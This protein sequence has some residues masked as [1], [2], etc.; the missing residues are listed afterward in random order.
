MANDQLTYLIQE[1]L[2]SMKAGGEIAKKATAEINNAASNQKLKSALEA[3]NKTAE[4]W[5]KRVDEALKESG[6]SSEPGNRIIEALY[7]V[8]TDVVKKYTDDYSRD[9]AIIETGQLALH[10]WIAA[11]GTMDAY[12]KRAGLTQTSK[13]METCRKEAEQ[14]DK[15]HTDIA[16]E[17]IESQN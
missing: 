16:L 9:L 17:I 14:A 12:A 7:D 5:R 15:Q 11:F 2:A 8:S 6:G 4:Q 1:S 13:N 3:G 10:Y